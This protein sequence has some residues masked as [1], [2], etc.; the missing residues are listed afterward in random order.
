MSESYQIFFRT[1]KGGCGIEYETAKAE[2]MSVFK[3]YDVQVT[4]D[5]PSKM[6][7]NAIINGISNEELIS[8]A[9]LLGYTQGILLA[10]EEPYLGEKLQAKHSARWFTGWIRIGDKKIHLTEL[11]RQDEDKLLQEAPHNRRFFVEYDGKI[12]QATGHRY[13]RGISPNDAMFI[14]NISELRGDE[15]ILDPFAGIGGIVIECLK[16]GLKVFASD[17]DRFI[18]PGLAHVSNKRCSIAD[19]RFLPFKEHTF[20]A[21]IT[22]PPFV[23][24]LRDIVL[25]SIP[26]LCRVMKPSGKIIMLIAEDMYEQVTERLSNFGYK[27]DRKFRIRRH[28]HLTSY[29]LRFVDV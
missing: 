1:S 27:L 6:R 12:V 2:F 3:D 26:E 28:A 4:L 14:V 13:H 16:R 19:A 22:E 29:V 8:R 18:L 11:Y 5:L 24:K 10:K 7:M 21:I 9:K 15:L 23:T 25:S 20:D 17:V